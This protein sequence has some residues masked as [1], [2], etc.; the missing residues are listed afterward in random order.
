MEEDFQKILL[1]EP[2][3]YHFV[4]GTSI[5]KAIELITTGA[6]AMGTP[7]YSEKDTSYFCAHHQYPKTFTF[8]KGFGAATKEDVREVI[9][10]FAR[11]HA[12]EDY[13]TTVFPWIAKKNVA[14]E[15]FTANELFK[16]YKTTFNELGYCQ[17]H[18]HKE[19]FEAQKR[20]G[21]ALY[22]NENLLDYEISPDPETDYYTENNAIKISSPKPISADAFIAIEPLGKKEKE[23]LQEYL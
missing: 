15:D 18:V 10:D 7:P 2:K 6:M 23:I 12:F 16:K 14:F 20:R 17:D 8:S 21:V 13:L 4:R 22:C 9:L 5:E 11:M 19:Y 3:N 1:G